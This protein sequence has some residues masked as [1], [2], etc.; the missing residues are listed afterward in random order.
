MLFTNAATITMPLG[1]GLLAAAT[2][3]ALPMWLMAVALLAARWPAAQL[4][5]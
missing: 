5:S 3:P 4:K 1:F 2:T